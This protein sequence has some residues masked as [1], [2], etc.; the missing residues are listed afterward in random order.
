M[1]CVVSEMNSQ[2]SFD[3]AL[4]FSHG[5]EMIS[6]HVPAAGTVAVPL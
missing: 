6:L 1:R 5:D 4:V 3:G 2:N